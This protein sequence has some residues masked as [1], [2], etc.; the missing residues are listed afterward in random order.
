VVATKDIT[1][2]QVVRACI[3]GPD[4][5]SLDVLVEAT[6]APLKVC[7]GAMR[8]A[9]RRGLIDYGVSMRSA[10]AEPAGLALLSASGD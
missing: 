3:H 2:E 1:D 5:F 9:I 7:E 8:R 10:W 6:G 4:V